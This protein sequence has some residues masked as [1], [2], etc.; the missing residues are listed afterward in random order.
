VDVD[1]GEEAAT[2]V[3]DYPH[4]VIEETLP[5]DRRRLPPETALQDPA[6]YLG[7]LGQAVRRAL[8]QARARADQVLG[9]GVDFTSC[10]I[11]PPGGDGAPLCGQSRCR[12]NPHAWVKLWKHHA[13]H[14][15]ADR[16]NEVGRN[17]QEFFL[18]A[19]GG[20]YS[21][22]WFFSKVLETVRHAPEV[23]QEAAR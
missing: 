7:V 2:A 15:E 1:S 13:A 3:C 21:S 11:L 17:R 19:Y 20:R 18:N 14:P 23:Y 4:G 12:R 10:T 8:H 22:E 16:I 6:D 9:I 5:G